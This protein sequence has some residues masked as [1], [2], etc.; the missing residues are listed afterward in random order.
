MGVILDMKSTV[1]SM[2]NRTISMALSDFYSRNSHYRT[3]LNLLT[4]DSQNDVVLAAFQVIF[5][6]TV[7]V[8]YSLLKEI[9]HGNMKC[10]YLPVDQAFSNNCLSNIDQMQLLI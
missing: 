5:S 1:G 8:T 9:P 2:A 3:R 6:F 7:T 4:R 10:H